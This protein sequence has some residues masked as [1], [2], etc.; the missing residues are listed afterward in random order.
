MLQLGQNVPLGILIVAVASLLFATGA[1]IQHLAVGGTVDAEAENRSMNLGQLVRLITN[2]R[3]LLG[4]S[5]I[6]IGALS[7]IYALM[8]A[9]VTVVQP[10]GILAVPWSVLMA[11]KI[12][13]HKVTRPMWVAVTMTIAGIAGFTFFSAS[14]AAPDSTVEPIQVVVGSIIVY[15]I[16]FAFAAAGLKGPNAQFRSL[17]W[18]TGGSFLY[19]LS[20]AL[21]KSVTVMLADADVL[22]RPM[23]WVVVPL[24]LGCY[25]FGGIMIQQGYATG[26]AEIVVA[27]MTTTDPVVGVSFGLILLGEGVRITGL[28]ALGMA[29]GAFVAIWGVVELSKHHPDAVARREHQAA[30]AG[31]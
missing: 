1:T 12:H 24:L 27:S 16:G 3:W 15:A 22:T 20:S 6:A 4:L 14:T 26:P 10:V 19:G 21:I 11:A 8:I 9:P 2:P 17:M 29:I 18:A 28:D 31:G 25:V 5:L 23:F 7:H 13:R 30:L